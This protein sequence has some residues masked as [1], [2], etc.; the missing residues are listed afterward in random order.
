VYRRRR[1][2]A[3]GVLLALVAGI[4]LGVRALPGGSSGSGGIDVSSVPVKRLIGQRL[5][6]RMDGAVTPPLLRAARRGEIGGVILFPP[7]GQDVKQLTEQIARLQR[8]ARQGHNPPLLVAIDQEGG[9]IKRLPDG[10]PKSSPAQLGKRGDTT[11]AEAEGA[12]TGRYLA[13]L[14]LSVDLAPVLDVPNSD[15]S[16]IASRSFGTD[17]GE[18]A[19]LGTE[20]ANGLQSGGVAATA[21]HFPGLGAATANTDLGPS[22][23][24]GSKR[25]LQPDL[26]PFRYAIDAGVK[27]VM[28]S[29]ATYPAYGGNA[30]KTSPQTD[31]ASVDNAPAVFSSAVVRDLLR[32]E[33]GFG[34]VVISDDL[35]AGAV[36]ES[37]APAAAGLAASRAGVDVLLFAHTDPSSR[38]TP[39][40][41]KA[42]RD[43]TLTRPQLEDSYRRIVTL[44]QSLG[45]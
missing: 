13:R 1:A 18:V 11:A 44:K 42:A 22:V 29:N 31:T 38:V 23:I 28:I 36:S 20:F 43:G 16:F 39:E 33:L 34:G 12:A 4:V 17:Q 30:D 15:A 35:E 3:L 10:P 41:L 9:A 8:A 5:M 19:K 40:L 45:G 37:R 25:D 7:A 14:G 27:L 6:V 24:G 2:A 32:D 21:K 26:I